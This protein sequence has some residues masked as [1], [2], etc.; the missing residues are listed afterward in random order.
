ATF[1]VVLPSVTS[2]QDQ[3]ASLSAYNGAYGYVRSGAPGLGDEAVLRI[4]HDSSS[5]GPATV[6]RFQVTWRDRN[7]VAWLELAVRAGDQTADDALR[8]AAAQQA[9]IAA[10]LTAY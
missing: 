5:L 4:K 10:D 6:D 2:A 7:V 1:A 8:L 3:Y 9:R